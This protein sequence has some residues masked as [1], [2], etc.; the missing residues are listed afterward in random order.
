MPTR[1]K[2]LHVALAQ[3]LA[4][5]PGGSPFGDE[6]RDRICPWWTDGPCVQL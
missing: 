2:C 3:A 6:V 1:V 4:E 5:G